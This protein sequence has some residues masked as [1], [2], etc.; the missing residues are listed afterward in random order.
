[1]PAEK[2]FTTNLTLM[3]KNN[4]WRNRS[5]RNRKSNNRKNKL[6]LSNKKFKELNKLKPRKVNNKKRKKKRSKRSK[7]SKKNKKKKNKRRK[8]SLK[9]KLDLITELLIWEQQ[10]NM[11]SSD[12]NP[13]SAK[14]LENSCLI[15]T[16][17]KFILQNWLEEAQ[18][19]DLM[20]LTS[21]ILVE[22][23]V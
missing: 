7:R 1:M 14:S 2:Y 8:P 10:Q 16:L 13:V 18:K 21:H 22:R 23:L 4:K 6:L 19:E 11:L 5:Q 15:K 12:F 9:W 3:S 20:S 17:L